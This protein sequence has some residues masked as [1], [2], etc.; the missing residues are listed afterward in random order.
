MPAARRPLLRAVAAAGLAV[1]AGCAQ[2]VEW[3][4]ELAAGSELSVRG[5]SLWPDRAVAQGVASVTDGSF[6]SVSMGYARPVDPA[7]G[8]GA[9]LIVRG[10]AYWVP[11]DDWTLQARLAGYRYPGAPLYSG[12]QRREL[13][14]GAAWRDLLSIESSGIRLDEGDSHAYRA[15]DLG[16]RWPLSSR[17]SLAAGW[18]VAELPGWPGMHYHYADAGIAWHAGPWRAQLS[19]LGASDEVVRYLGDAARARTALSVSRAF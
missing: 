12:Y 3:N 14:L 16:L 18:G 4:A 15:V 11:A 2:A 13:T 6:W 7:P 17:F 1:A 19:R 8:Q 9:E 5:I 10:A